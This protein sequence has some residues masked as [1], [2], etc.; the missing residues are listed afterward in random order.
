MKVFETSNDETGLVVESS[1]A[2]RTVL[3]DAEVDVGSLVE[4]AIQQNAH[5]RSRKGRT[6][7]RVCSAAKCQM[8]LGLLAPELEL[9]RF[10]P[11]ARIP[12][13]GRQRNDQPLAGCD[14]PTSDPGFPAGHAKGYL[15]R[16]LKPQDFLN[17][18]RNLAAILAKLLLQ[19]LILGQE[20]QAIPNQFG[21]RILARGKQEYRQPNS[22]WQIGRRAIWELGGRKLR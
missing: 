11:A 10:L 1:V 6:N 16:S 19:S 18:R 8:L 2:G 21:A 15:G 14:F 13:R 4:E 5:L 12:V 7:A 9:V 20:A 22:L 17:E 3:L